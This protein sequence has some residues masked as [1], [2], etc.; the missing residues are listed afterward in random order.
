MDL[1]KKAAGPPAVFDPA[2][3][4]ARYVDLG[5]G[6]SVIGDAVWLH[7]SI[8]G[9]VDEAALRAHERGVRFD[10]LQRDAVKAIILAG[11]GKELVE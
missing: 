9:D 2:Q 5:G 4:L 8:K 7:W 10:P 3:W 1:S 6:Y 11:V